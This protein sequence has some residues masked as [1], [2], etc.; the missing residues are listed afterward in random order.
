[1]ARTRRSTASASFER[2]AAT[3]LSIGSPDHVRP[4]PGRSRPPTRRSPVPQS[5]TQHHGLSASTGSSFVGSARE[6]GRCSPLPGL[7]RFAWSV[8]DGVG[9]GCHFGARCRLR[10]GPCRRQ[11]RLAGGGQQPPAPR[12]TSPA[13]ASPSGAGRVRALT[14]ALRRDSIPTLPLAG[15]RESAV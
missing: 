9:P 12:P 2:T 4:A 11:G 15:G 1:M 3:S 10:A 6:I 8:W 14:G 7:A 5:P 13:P